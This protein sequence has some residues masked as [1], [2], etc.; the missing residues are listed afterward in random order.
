MSDE[1]IWEC[2][3]CGEVVENDEIC[4]CCGEIYQPVKNEP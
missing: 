1:I 2:P 4:P 3:C